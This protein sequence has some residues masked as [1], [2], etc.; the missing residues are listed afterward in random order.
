MLESAQRKKPFLCYL[1][2]NT[3]H[4]PF[5][6]KEEDRKVIA[7]ILAQPKFDHLDGGLKKRL[8]LYLGMIRN[9]DWN[10]GKLMQFLDDEELTDDTILIFK[11]DNGSLL[12]PQYFNAGMRGKKTEIWEGG[13][14]FPAS[15]GGPRDFGKPRGV[16]GL[17]QV[18]DL[19]PTLLDCEIRPKEKVI[20]DGMSL[21]PILR[22]KKKVSDDRILIINYSRMPGFSNYPSPHSQTQMR[23]DQAAVLWKRWR[24]LED[25]ELYDLPPIPCKRRARHWRASR[26]G[27]QNV[28]TSIPG[29]TGSSTWRTRNSAS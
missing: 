7:E 8:A 16:G 29:G 28:N 4:G 6:P 20:F 11:T 22:G 23:A 12:G 25:R 21:A 26:G 24:L 2:T 9:I 1:A 27:G 17:T 13:T 14:G 15:S 19:L 18:Q 10:M 5:W 3:P